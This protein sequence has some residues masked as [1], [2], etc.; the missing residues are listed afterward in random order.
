MGAYPE[1]QKYGSCCVD[2]DTE[3]VA[4]EASDSAA[5]K[6]S[7]DNSS[8]QLVEVPDEVALR[9]ERWGWYAYEAATTPYWVGV[10][11][12][13]PVLVLQQAQF[14]AHARFCETSGWPIAECMET[15]WA[16]DVE[17][18]GTCRG[19]YS[20]GASTRTFCSDAG[21][22]W[23]PLERVAA[24][25]VQFLWWELHYAACRQVA[26]VLSV[27]MQIVAFLLFSSMADYGAVRRRM[28]AG[29]TWLGLAAVLG[30][31]AG[32]APKYYAYNTLLLSVSSF[33]LSF[34]GVFYNS[35]LPMMARD[36]VRLAASKEADAFESCSA[37]LSSE[38][39]ICGLV[40]Q[41]AFMVLGGFWLFATANAWAT[42]AA[43]AVTCAVWAL[44]VTAFTFASLQNRVGKQLPEGQGYVGTSLR[45]L[46]STM[47]TVRVD[48][49]QLLIFLVSWFVH[50]DGAATVGAAAT[51]FA[52]NELQ[53]PASMIMLSLVELSLLAIFGARA[54]L[55][56]HHRHGVRA[57]SLLLLSIAMMGACPMWGVFALTTQAEFFAVAGIYGLATGVYSTFNRSLFAGCIPCG[58]EAEF[59][60]FYEVT[61]KGTAWV[62]P[63]MVAWIATSSGSYRLAFGATV[64]FFV[65]GGAILVFF[66]PDVA[67][68]E[69][70][71]AEAK[72]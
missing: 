63:L 40:A 49:R 45:R 67:A 31:A 71:Q 10:M 15:G 69:R 52:S 68:S 60:G 38:G 13:M 26:D 50:S 14:V 3:E 36:A 18:I 4:S 24:T 28:L 6:R 59:F 12:L 22:S 65:L 47:S 23:T 5:L 57:K 16:Q 35:Y 25:R 42:Y 46:A 54:A 9:W 1:P 70:A 11:Q 21:G 27:L 20:A 37:R 32:L 41:V 44:V 72:G 7:P 19:A 61:N 56:F 58:R 51:T 30:H 39:L 8:P 62:G 53:I 34:A 2:A 55:W 29:C 48:L 66:D 33:F 17:L 64:V 43:F